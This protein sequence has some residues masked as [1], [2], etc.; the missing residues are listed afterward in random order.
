MNRLR[1]KKGWG[2]GKKVFT[3][4]KKFFSKVPKVPNISI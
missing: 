2:F 3:A 1:L 4:V